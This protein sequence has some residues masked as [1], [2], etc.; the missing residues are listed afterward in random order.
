VSID[1]GGIFVSFVAVAT[2][3]SITYTCFCAIRMAMATMVSIT[4]EIVCSH[5]FADCDPHLL[6]SSW[7]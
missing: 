6:V 2:S 1:F 7:I 4:E 5:V 3:I